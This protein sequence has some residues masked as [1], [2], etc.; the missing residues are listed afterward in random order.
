MV[1]QGP[2]LQTRSLTYNDN[3]NLNPFSTKKYKSHSQVLEV[4]AKIFDG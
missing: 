1:L 3:G 2:R 4:L